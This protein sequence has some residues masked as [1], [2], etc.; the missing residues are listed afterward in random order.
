[1]AFEPTLFIDIGAENHFYTLRQTYL[2]TYYVAGPG[3]FGNAVI[4]GVYQGKTCTEVRSMHVCNLS[5][6]A[7][8]A[9]R[10][11]YE[12]GGQLGLKCT[13][14]TEADLYGMLDKIKR[15]TEDERKQRQAQWEAD[16]LARA[17]EREA[18]FFAK[19]DA[20]IYPFGRYADTPFADLPDDFCRWL[21]ATLPEFETGSHMALAA[22]AVAEACPEKCAPLFDPSRT[23]AFMGERVTLDVEVHK[24]RAFDGF[25]GRTYLVVMR[26]ASGACV[27][28]RGKFYAKEGTK[29]RIR[30]TVKEY[31]EYRGQMQTQVQRVAEV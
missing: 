14:Y 6:N 3:D 24:C 8:D 7:A 22:T 26:E 10:K 25:Y 27:V 20:R 11:L 2:H 16:K 13:R 31:T 1:M 17:A 15:A 30:C 18:E 23:L 5:Q 28:S 21:K 19:L 29:M 9:I 12:Y 4:G